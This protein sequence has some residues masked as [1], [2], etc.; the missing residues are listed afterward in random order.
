LVADLQQGPELL[1]PGAAAELVPVDQHHRLAGA[2]VLVVDLDVD[3]I[4]PAERGERRP[5]G[6]GGL[7]AGARPRSA[8]ATFSG[9]LRRKFR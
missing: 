3:G 2:V 1:V 6:V 4:L 7:G 9:G 5:F 8:A